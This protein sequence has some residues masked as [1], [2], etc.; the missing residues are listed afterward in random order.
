MTRFLLR[1]GLFIILAFGSLLA[2]ADVGET[3]A[4]K[5]ERAKLIEQITVLQKDSVGHL[6]EIVSIQEQIFSLDERIFSSYKET[7][8]RVSAQKITQGSNDRLI[9]Y[10][11]VS[12]SL[13]A[14]FFAILLLGAR[15]QLQQKNQTGLRSFYR[16][17]AVE[18]AGKVSAEKTSSNRMLRVNIVVIAGLILM[19]VSILAYL[20]DSL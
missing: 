15:S 19:S 4:L 3:H 7:I 6:Q 8:D 20:I 9:V 12:F 5:N 1:F 2:T 17:M 18:F 11:A 16:E 14:L 10:L 13:V